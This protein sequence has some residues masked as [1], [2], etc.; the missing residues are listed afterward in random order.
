MSDHILLAASMT[1]IL[2]AEAARAVA[3]LVATGGLAKLQGAQGAPPGGGAA[4]AAAA[5][6]G[7]IFAAVVAVLTS[8]DMYYTAK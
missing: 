6:A 2:W 4:S 8:A 7:I 3:W 1:G 5:G